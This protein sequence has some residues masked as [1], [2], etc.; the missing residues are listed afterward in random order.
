MSLAS[1]TGFGGAEG[2]AGGWT[3]AVEARSVN[4][5]S[6][7]VRFR[8]P[9]GSDVLERAAREAAQSAFVRGQVGVNLTVVRAGGAGGRRVDLA[10][11][12]AYLAAGAALVESGRVGRP[13]LDGLLALPGVLTEPEPQDETGRA[14]R[15]SEGVRLI[16]QAMSALAQARRAEGAALEVVLVR[17][18]DQ[19]DELVAEAGAEAARQ[20]AL[21]KARLE[22]RLSE[23]AGEALSPER[24]AQ[25]AAALALRA[26]VTEEL[27]RLAGHVGAA[28]TLIAADAPA[29]RRLDFLAQE[30]M[31]EANTLCSKSASATLTRVGLDLK[32]A[33]DQLR[34][35]VQ[36]VE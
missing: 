1:M 30:F 24:V 23:L 2:A 13:T 17:L 22:K 20:P 26:D 18:L 35:Q 19:I 14:A 8:G 31:R 16:G 29:G 21:M 4:G 6:L 25:E 33:V 10:A 7:D 34:E 15:E 3:L 9:P 11:A 12:E 27:D 28:R 5:R 36:N 32:T